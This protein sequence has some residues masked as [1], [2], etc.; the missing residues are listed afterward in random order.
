[1]E[2]ERRAQ[3]YGTLQG[4]SFRHP[5]TG[6]IYEVMTVEYDI[7]SDQVVARRAPVE[8]QESCNEDVLLYK[9]EGENGMAQLVDQ[10]DMYAG[11]EERSVKWPQNEQEML[12][13]Q[14]AEEQWNTI[15]TKLT[16]NFEEEILIRGRFRAV[17]MKDKEGDMMALRLIDSKSIEREYLEKEE[18]IIALPKALIKMALAF[19][20]EGKAHPGRNRTAANLIM[21]YYWEGMGE[22]IRDYVAQ[23]QNCQ[24]RKSSN[25]GAKY[26]YYM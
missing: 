6:I 5:E 17:L 23:C 2:G 11:L 14:K 3:E 26:Q 7:N 4:R 9:V 20:H 15:I 12:Q 21:R 8:G 1:M 18:K 16:E 13:L 22:D 19:E 24:R 25:I 10:Y